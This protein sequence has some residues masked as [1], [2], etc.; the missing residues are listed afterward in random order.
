MEFGDTMSA[1]VCVSRLDHLSGEENVMFDID[2][3]ETCLLKDENLRLK[4]Q[5]SEAL[6]LIAGLERKL[7]E[8]T[9]L[10]SDMQMEQDFKKSKDDRNHIQQFFI[11]ETE[12]S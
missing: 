8:V 4:K 2:Y 3:Q 11:Y 7:N 10:N 6:N 5:L 1:S 9:S 12:I